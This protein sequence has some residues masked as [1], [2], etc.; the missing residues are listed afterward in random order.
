M[1]A[2]GP[3]PMRKLRNSCMIGGR[4]GRISA[5]IVRHENLGMQSFRAEAM[6]F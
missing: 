2:S 4:G 3:M 1:P 6:A 5:M